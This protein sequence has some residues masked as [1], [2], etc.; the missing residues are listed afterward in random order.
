MQ[1]I[2]NKMN[3]FIKKAKRDKALLLMVTPVI[4]YY[5]IFHYKPMY[6]VIIAFKD[7]NP[8]LGI[9]GSPWIGLDNFKL[10]FSSAFFFRLIKNTFLISFYGLVFGFPFP[11]GFALILNEIKHKAYKKVVQTVSYLPH[12]ISVVIVCGMI[13]NFLSPQTGIVSKVVQLFGGT[14]ENYLLNSKYFRFIYISSGIWQS[15]G[16][17]SIIYLAA[18][19]GIDEQLYE[20]ARLDGANRLK[21]IFYITI[22]GIV[23]TIIILLILNLGNI[24]SVGFEKIILLYNPATYNVADVISTFTY[25]QGLVGLK[26]SYGAA[27]GLFNSVIN[28][29]FLVTANAI[30]RK[31]S[32]I[33]LW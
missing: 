13:V 22:P 8:G 19:T 9:W 5:I 27:V 4:I 17:G 30:S 6:G 24:M 33:S 25:R 15:F 16:W 29:L 32:E 28:C 18:I 12:F 21:Q 1:N 7:F 2:S 23:P 3:L 26:Y 31:V 20:A 14:P 11:I 10:F